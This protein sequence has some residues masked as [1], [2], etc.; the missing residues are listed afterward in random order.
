M[1]A[2]V[3]DYDVWHETDVNIETVI[4]NAIKNE[5]AVRKII[6]RAIPRIS[7]DRNCVCANA[8][9]GSIV[10]PTDKIP[11]ETKRKLKDLIEKY[12]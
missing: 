6:K 8:L 7:L 10:T 9:T 3:T 11:V 2:T 5:E 4:S 12:L 1:I